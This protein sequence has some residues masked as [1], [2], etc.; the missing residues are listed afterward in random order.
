MYVGHRG[1]HTGVVNSKAFELAGVTMDT[2]D[3]EGGRFFRE[4]GEFTGK[5]AEHAR[6]AFRGV[7]TWPVIDR[8]ARAKAVGVRSRE[9]AAAGLT[10]TTD[11]WAGRDSFVAYQ[12]A[13]AAGDL[14]FRVSYMPSGTGSIYKAFKDAGITSGFGDEWL[15][16]G[17]V[18]FGADGSASERTMRMSTPF[19]GT[20]DYGI[21][22][23]NQEEI[24]AAVDD[25]VAH[26]FRIGIHANGDVT[27]DMV[28]NAYERVLKNHDGPNPRL[29]IEHCSLVNP[30]TTQTH[31]G[32]WRDPD[33]FLYLRA[34]PRQQVG[35][36]RRRED[37]K[38]VR[39]SQFSRRRHPG[40]ARVRFRARTV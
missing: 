34:L 32:S 27:I 30:C 38:H 16:V 26:G 31:Q 35:R 5:V 11:A 22:T 21:L 17:A 14:H 37:E 20:D 15:R 8:A 29:R 10:S 23:M 6:D 28:L 4:N 3:P 36:L 24:D 25:A 9:M 1:G 12:D 33:T 39:A 13:R 19:E 7:G 18:K 40:G 2:P